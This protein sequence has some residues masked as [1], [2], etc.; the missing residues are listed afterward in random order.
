MI[1][2]LKELIVSN[3]KISRIKVL[4]LTQKSMGQ[5]AAASVYLYSKIYDYCTHNSSDKRS[6]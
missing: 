2:K 3:I 4:A 5:L 1:W 6:S